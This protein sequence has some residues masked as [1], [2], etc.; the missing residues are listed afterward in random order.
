MPIYQYKCTKCLKIFDI[1]CK[2]KNRKSTELCPYCQ[3][4]ANLIISPC[5]FRLYGEDWYKPNKKG[6]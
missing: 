6:D 5:T 2:L 3:G 1:T 4:L